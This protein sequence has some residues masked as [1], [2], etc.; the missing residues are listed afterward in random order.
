[1]RPRTP[2]LMAAAIGILGCAPQAPTLEQRLAMLPGST[3]FAIEV[4]E[5]FA[6]AFDLRLVQ[7]LDHHDPEAG[8]F[9]QRILVEHRGYERPVVLVT[10]GYDLGENL[11]GEL[12]EMLGANQIRVEHRYVGDSAPEELLWE[13]LT[14]A[15]ASSDAHR[16]VGLL[17]EIYPG[18][19]VSTGWSKGGQTALIY[20][21]HFPDDVV[22]TVAYDAPLPLALEDPRIDAHFVEVGDFECRQKIEVFQRMALERKAELLPLFVWYAKGKGWGLSIGEETVF[23]YT[24]LEFPFS[25]WQYS[26]ADCGA[27]P[28]PGAG[29]E[30]VLEKLVEV[31][32]AGWFA[33]ASLDSPSFHQ[34]CTELGFYGYVEEPFADLLV[35]EDYPLCV[36]APGWSPEDYDPETMRELD[37]WLRTGADRVMSIYGGVDPWSAP[38]IP[39]GGQEQ[40]QFWRRD[41]NHFTVI[42]NLSAADQAYARKTLA[43]WLG[44]S[45]RRGGTVK[46]ALVV[47]AAGIGSRYGGLKQVDKVGPGGSALMDY[48][49]Y[50]ALAS[51]YRAGRDGRPAAD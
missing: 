19:W 8:T 48:T 12:A 31:V 4:E 38:S 51:G 43:R 22:A 17:R 39:V 41:G 32:D 47:L 3:V 16:I 15:E 37:H 6:E 28:G 40:V 42:R 13:Y 26:E 30:A 7:P 5:P 44:L 45:Y 29:T 14:L 46:P 20:R 36:F 23:D 34:F 25:F 27:I 9:S 1:M 33:D 18:P 50:D 49:I 21:S 2:A 35:A 24:V 11:V 10:E